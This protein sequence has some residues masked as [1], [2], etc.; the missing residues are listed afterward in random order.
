MLNKLYIKNY[1]LISELEIELNNGFTTITGETGAGKSILLGALSLITGKRAD[2]NVLLDKEQKCVVEGTF[3]IEKFN[4]QNLFQELDIDYEKTTIIRREINNAGKTRAFVNDTPV[5][6]S[7]LKQLGEKLIDVH[8]QHNNIF[9]NNANFYIQVVDAFADLIKQ[10]NEYSKKYKTYRNLLSELENLE[11][12]ILKS[13]QDLDYYHFQFNQL[14]EANL[15]IDEETE[16]ELELNK[17]NNA[18]EIKTTL[19]SVYKALSESDE[20]IILTLKNLENTLNSVSKLGINTNEYQKRLESIII[21][22][23]DINEDVD[24]QNNKI[25][26]DVDK[27]EL[28]NERLNLIFGLHQKFGVNSNQD[29]IKIKEDFNGKLSNFAIDETKSLRLK[30][31]VTVLNKELFSLAK[32]ISKTRKSKKNEI[33]QFVTRILVLLGINNAIFDINFKELS[34][35]TKTGIDDINFLF[36]A[37][38]NI[39][40]SEISKTASG[41]EVSRIMLALK[42]LLAKSTNL[43]TIIFDEIDTGVSGEIAA[44][45]AE[46]MDDLSLTTQVISITHLPQIAVKGNEQFV[47]YKDDS[48]TKSQTKIT[49]LGKEDRINEIAKMLSGK[50]LSNAAI[51]N[52]KILLN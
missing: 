7:T 22:L 14:E 21:E 8:S 37:N 17:L 51:E 12:L 43:P 9:L 24:V 18:E 13:K 46:I 19:S 2:T 11:N 41:G 30:K 35:L 39:E 27:I 4:L 23:Q 3:E 47:V 40:K 49:K 32:Q 36:S 34:E 5:S 50:E 42:S 31:E 26:Y 33:E 16:L 15:I 10:T 38:K 20:N 52:A 44:K 6:V 28:L 25:E 29:L 45:M 1:I 48:D